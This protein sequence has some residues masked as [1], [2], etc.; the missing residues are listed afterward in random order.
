MSWSNEQPV[1]T[2]PTPLVLTATP[3]STSQ[4]NLSWNSVSS[5]SGYVVY[6]LNGTTWTEYGNAGTGTGSQVTGLNAGSSYT[7]KVGDI[8][9]WG[10]NWSNVVSPFT[11]PVAPTL[12]ATAVSTSSVDVSWSNVASATGYIVN[13]SLNGAVQQGF[14]LQNNSTTSFDFQNLSPGT[15]YGFQVAAYN[16]AGDSWSQPVT[17]TTFL[18]APTLTAQRVSLLQA[19]LSWNSV[20]GAAVYLVEE[21]NAYSSTWTEISAVT[22]TSYDIALPP[23]NSE[24]AVVAVGVSGSAW[25]NTVAM[26][27]TLKPVPV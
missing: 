20:A 18:A 25:S 15:T 10:L 6:E 26:T 4:I 27:V 24:Y 19:D 3:I 22:G 11:F 5:A 12:T 21:W 14:T 23:G 1:T 8:G 9:P 13:V 7:F 2:L 17:A 16:S